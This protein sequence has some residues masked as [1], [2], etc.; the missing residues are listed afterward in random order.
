MGRFEP[1]L[2]FGIALIVLFM[3]VFLSSMARLLA[4]LIFVLMI[5]QHERGR[6]EFN[7]LEYTIL[8]PIGFFGVA[9][10][11]TLIRRL[12]EGDFTWRAPGFGFVWV[13]LACWFIVSAVIGLLR[14]TPTD[15]WV[16]ELVAAGLYGSFFFATDGLR[17]PSDFR[18]VFFALLAGAAVVTLEYLAAL[19]VGIEGYGPTGRIVTRQGNLVVLVGPLLVAVFLSGRRGGWLWLIGLL[20]LSAVVLL[21]QQRSLFVAFPFALLLPAAVALWSRTADLRR[22]ILLVLVITVGAV[23]AWRFV[24][25]ASLRGGVQVSEAIE[26]RAEEATAP[27]SAAA[28]AIRLIS[29]AKVWRERI[30]ERPIL[31]WGLGDVASIPLIRTRSHRALIVDNSYITIVWKSGIIGLLLFLTLYGIGLRK[32]AGLARHAHPEARILGAGIVGALAGVLLLSMAST[33]VSHYRFNAILG[34]LLASTAAA[35]RV[36]GRGSRR[37]RGTPV[38]D[39]RGSER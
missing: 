23:A 29:F 39:P 37:G 10:V 34:I 33:L 30:L 4:V 6:F 32:A 38:T 18:L 16:V 17:R 28:I 5:V 11:Q 7:P 36:Y 15:T 9:L 2:V 12:D 22:V 27:Q 24:G 14:E 13:G 1:I 20:P 19:A 21:T 26:A 31:G 25:T 35:E 3:P 8:I